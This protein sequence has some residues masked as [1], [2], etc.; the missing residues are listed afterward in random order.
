MQVG[1][2]AGGERPAQVQRDGGAVVGAQQPVRVGRAVGRG[3]VEPVHRVAAVGGQLDPGAGLGRPGPGL[4]VLPGQPADL[5]DRHARAVGEHDGHLQDRLQ[6]GPNPV[7]GR[8]GERLGAVAAL[9]HE[10]LAPGDRGQPGPQL[11]AFAGEDQ[12]R[13]AG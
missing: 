9:Q 10:R 11:V 6:L 12:R 2:A 5:D 7:R 1:V 4:G 13:Q 3:E 8:P